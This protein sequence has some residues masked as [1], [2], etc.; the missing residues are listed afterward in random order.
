MT[1]KSTRS[2]PW[3]ANLAIGFIKACS[4]LPLE[5]V[6]AFGSFLAHVSMLVPNRHGRVS[7]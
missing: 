4:L 1:K 6:R 3:Q 7:R 5:L 2:V